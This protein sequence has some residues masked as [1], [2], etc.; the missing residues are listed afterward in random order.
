MTISPAWRDS[1]DEFSVLRRVNLNLLPI[2]RALLRLR[3]VSR[4]AQ[5]LHLTQPA[6]SASL[7]KLRS[8][9]GDELLVPRGRSM[10]LTLKARG[11]LVELERTLR[12]TSVLLGE[13]AFDSATTRRRYHVAS[14]DYVAAIA[15]PAAVR[16]LAVEA[17]FASI[18]AFNASARS[19]EDL[20]VGDIDLIVIPEGLSELAPLRR[21]VGDGSIQS[22]LIFEDRL[23]YV[24]SSKK[25]A[26]FK[27]LD[28]KEYLGLPHAS[29]SLERQLHASLEI[30]GLVAQHLEQHDRVLLG[31]F[32][33]LP[34]VS[35]ASDCV[36]VVPQWIAKMFAEPLGL[37]IVE[38]PVQ[39]KP[40]RLEMLWT[41]SQDNDAGH[42]WF[43]TM[44]RDSITETRDK[45][46]PEVS[47]KRP[48]RRK[49]HAPRK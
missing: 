22:E 23:V 27:K 49:G 47:S 29:F 3:N 41:R 20:I 31:S 2:L 19:A 24:V 17:P 25:R 28:K 9:F 30:E 5:E 12:S 1:P 38:P 6:V 32:I 36:A 37:Q 18:H 39:F 44:F 45:L 35:A 4:A 13:P 46:W 8:H 14:A 40:I 10:E 15:L 21:G 16:R 34:F 43:R 7:R 33:L 26:S 42:R 48:R 11:M